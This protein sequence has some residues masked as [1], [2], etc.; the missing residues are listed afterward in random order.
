LGIVF[1]AG[2]FQSFFAGFQALLDALS[3]VKHDLRQSVSYSMAYAE[4]KCTHTRD[5]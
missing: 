5:I 1:V 3:L 2:I 4:S